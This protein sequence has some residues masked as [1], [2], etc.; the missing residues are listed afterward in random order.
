MGTFFFQATWWHVW[1]CG[2]LQRSWRS[3]AKDSDS[4]V[5]AMAERLMKRWDSDGVVGLGMCGR[6]DF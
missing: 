5:G 2:S 6:D 4:V 1:A 3:G